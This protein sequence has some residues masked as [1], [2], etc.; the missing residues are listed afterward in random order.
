MGGSTL[1]IGHLLRTFGAEFRDSHR[2]RL[3]RQQLRTMRAIEICRTAELGG[4]LYRCDQCGDEVVL[5]NSCRNRH[6]PKCQ[7]LDQ[8]RWLAKRHEELLPTSYFHVVFTLPSELA[9]IALANQKLIYDLLFRS[10]SHALQCAA[11]DAK[12]LGAKLGF[13]A[14]L[15]TWGQTLTLHPHVHCIV[16][17]GGLATEGKERWMAARKGYLLPIQILS[18]LY[19]GKFLDELR[20]AFRNGD[21]RFTE[22]VR[23]LVRPEA[24]DRLIDGLYRKGWIVYCKPP[25]AG[26][27]KTLDYLARYTHRIAISNRRLL[28]LRGRQ[29]TFSWRDN[30][31]GGRR[32][33]MTIPVDGLIRRFLLHVLPPR[34]VR[35]RY[36]GLLAHRDRRQRLQRCRTLLADGTE[37]G[38][39]APPQPTDWPSVL[40]RLTGSDPL[41]CPRCPHGRLAR[42]GPVERAPPWRTA[43]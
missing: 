22:S 27:E 23:D 32:R 28:R 33:E 21:L 19:R 9:P 3:S 42:I 13:V 41:K 7:R 29:V 39:A 20:Q 16:T 30:A 10:A 4:H 36:Y 11:A 8:A 1:E 43:A 35:I 5:P 6:C 31:Q 25:F 37:S 12:L 24:W 34:F 26:P 17:G 18:K 14:I 40:L 15:H 2:G 38:E